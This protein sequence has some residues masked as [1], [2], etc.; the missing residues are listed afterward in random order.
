VTA[1]IKHLGASMPKEKTPSKKNLPS[2]FLNNR[3]FQKEEEF[4]APNEKI[5]QKQDK[6][7]PSPVPDAVLVRAVAAAGFFVVVASPRCS[8]APAKAA[9]TGGKSSLTVSREILHF[10]DIFLV[11]QTSPISCAED[12]WKE[13]SCG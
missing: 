5:Q 6:L 2:F 12:Q 1:G 10:F 11:Q 13:Y 8:R 4:C 9:A 3:L 7:R